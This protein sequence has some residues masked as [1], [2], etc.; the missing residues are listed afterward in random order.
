MR[1]WGWSLKASVILS[2]FFTHST[3]VA[4][5]VSLFYYLHFI[6]TICY[7]GVYY[8]ILSIVISLS[9]MQSDTSNV[10]LLLVHVFHVC[11]SLTFTLPFCMLLWLAFVQ[12]YT[13]SSVSPTFV[14]L[15]CVFI[16]PRCIF[17]LKKH[18]LG[19]TMAM[20]NPLKQC[21]LSK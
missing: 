2:I 9:F 11:I 20:S 15:S 21:L 16:T 19:D 14:P 7:R 8:T 12:E 10:L 3:Y 17:L 1:K 5:R 18:N 13:T 6:V 4:L